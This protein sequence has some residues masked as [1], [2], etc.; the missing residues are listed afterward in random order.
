MLTRRAFLKT[1]AATAAI[2][3]S[4]NGL[5]ALQG[6]RLESN[7]IPTLVFA[8]ENNPRAAVFA[9][10]WSRGSTPVPST[11]ARDV[12]GQMGEIDHFCRIHPDGIVFGL[13]RD[14]DF[15]VLEHTAAQRGFSVHYRATHDFR[16]AVLVHE[17]DAPQAVALSLNTSLERAGAAWPQMLASALPLIARAQGALTRTRTTVATSYNGA[18]SGYLVSWMLKA[19]TASIDG[20]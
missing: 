13:T 12:A 9:N 20:S 8:D 6:K 3:G 18:D 4:S 1:T 5:A 15:F 10:S 19:T 11:T 16:G 7:D 17:I 2:A 14:S